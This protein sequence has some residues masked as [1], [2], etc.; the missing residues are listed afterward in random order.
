MVHKNRP[1]FTYISLVSVTFHVTALTALT[2]MNEFGDN[3]NQHLVS[4]VWDKSIFLIS[5]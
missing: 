3:V 2:V 5:N 4:L 1:L